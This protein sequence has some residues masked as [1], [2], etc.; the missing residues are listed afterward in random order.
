MVQILP[1]VPTFGSRLAE[2][3]S[4]AAS[5]YFEGQRERQIAKKDKTILE[6]ASDPN[7]TP[8]QRANLYA[9]LSEKKLNALSPVL[10]AL[11][12][13]GV[14]ESADANRLELY[15]QFLSPNQNQPSA[16]Q[17]TGM[18]S[19]N[20]PQE[21]GRPPVP[22]QAP[23][24]GMQN[25]GEL[26]EEPRRF[27]QEKVDS[28]LILD[29]NLGKYM[30]AEN[31]AV[32]RRNAARATQKLNQMKFQETQRHHEA[33]EKLAEHET[34]KEYY[35]GISDARRR[36]ENT[37]K[38][39]KTVRKALSTHKTGLTWE[40]FFKKQFAGTFLENIALTKEGAVTEASI[41]GFLE[42]GRELFG[43][44]LTN[45]DLAVIL[46][47]VVD[48]GKSNEANEALLDFAEFSANL[49]I[50]KA[51]IA[52]EIIKENKGYR[53]IGFE[54]KVEENFQKKYGDE[55]DAN[56]RKN[57]GPKSTDV[58]MRAPDGRELWVP[59]E[60]V[61]EFLDLKAEVI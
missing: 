45:A 53:P 40:N 10:S 46:G 36:A 21:T 57:F 8:A 47:K 12:K 4:G 19:G 55:I 3:L 29:P 34:S 41:P 49:A 26:M 28:A 6:Q 33:Q 58:H 7:L 24:E 54:A 17:G 44:Q 27:P 43:K 35:K 39:V 23:V 31:E 20:A 37:L 13:A 11:A 56:Y 42:G 48:L 32:D 51:E 25:V 61:Q 52:D 18:P 50:H 5:N 22:G 38:S 14:K 2:A 15:K 59:P 30:Q 9:G 60:K 1:P 16:P